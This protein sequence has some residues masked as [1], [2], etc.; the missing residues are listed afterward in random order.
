MAGFKKV[1]K[2]VFPSN[3]RKTSKGKKKC[4]NMFYRM[5]R[6]NKWLKKIRAKCRSPVSITLP[7]NFIKTGLHHRY[8]S[9]NVP[10]LFQDNRF[11]K[12]VLVTA[13]NASL[14]V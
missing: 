3:T 6:L 8:F 2:K 10:I 12:Q 11:I 14:F 9:R 5:D 7:Y 1:C 4:S 13:S